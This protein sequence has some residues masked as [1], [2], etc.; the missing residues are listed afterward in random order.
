MGDYD[1][2]ENYFSMAA[3][4]CQRVGN[5]LIGAYVSANRGSIAIKQGNYAQAFDLLA[6]AIQVL[7]EMGD[8][9]DVILCFEPLAFM[10][11]EQNLPIRAARLLGASEALRKELGVIRSQPLQ[12]DFEKCVASI[13]S[14]LD[15]VRFEIAWSEGRAMTYEQAIA[16]ALDR[17]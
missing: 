13:H 7:Q 9:E 3:K 11:L 1:Q 10:A 2:A 6:E 16:S 5:R 17:S 12:V 4:I 14:Q 8:K 15:E